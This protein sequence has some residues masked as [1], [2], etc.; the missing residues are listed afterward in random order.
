MAE[1]S[2]I[3]E[4]GPNG[5]VVF[6]R[7]FVSSESFKTLFRDGM[8]L[9]EEAAAYLDGQGRD[10]SRRLPRL[11]ALAYANE[12]MRLTTRL[13]QIASWLL[14]RRALAEGEMTE[15]EAKNQLGRVRL[16]KDA[17]SDE[18]R[19][20]LPAT[21]IA[22]VE[23]SLRLQARI[24]HLDTMMDTKPVRTTTAAGRNTVALQHMLLRSAFGRETARH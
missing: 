6:G 5:A 17:P 23:R 10:Q 12:S 19:A 1:V 8:A 7:D 21:L 24:Q 20:D 4:A 18:Q 9:V 16:Q 22:L 14:V 2:L 15:S 13:M 3:S 11:T